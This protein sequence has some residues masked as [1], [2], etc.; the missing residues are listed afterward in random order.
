MDGVEITPSE[1]TIQR[2]LA[3]E[4]RDVRKREEAKNEMHYTPAEEEEEGRGIPGPG[5]AGE[6]YTQARAGIQARLAQ[7]A[8][9]QDAQ[10]AAYHRRVADFKALLHREEAWVRDKRG[11]LARIAGP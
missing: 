6:R 1:R 8:Q 7:R 11:D 5:P 9:A 3:G 4:G 10:L 2:L